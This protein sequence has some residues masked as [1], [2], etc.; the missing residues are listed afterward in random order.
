METIRA[1]VT[2]KQ[3]RTGG[4]MAK[5][6]GKASFPERSQ[7][8]KAEIGE[9]WEVE[10]SGTNQK[11]SVNFLRLIRKVEK[12]S[13]GSPNRN[14]ETPSGKNAAPSEHRRH[15]DNLGNH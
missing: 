10:V 3:S 5:V 6:D 11:Q 7:S 12:Q 14:R 1:T 2:F 8:Q 9:T 15:H 13:H 4:P